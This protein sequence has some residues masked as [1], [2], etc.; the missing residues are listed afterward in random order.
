MGAR[1]EAVSA[2]TARILD[3]AARAFTERPYDDVSLAAIAD[4]SGVTVQT[5]L[6]RWGSKEGLV[7]AAALDAALVGLKRDFERRAAL[8]EHVEIDGSGVEL[9]AVDRDGK[10][11]FGDGERGKRGAIALRSRRALLTQVI[12]D[13]LELAVLDEGVTPV[14][15]QGGDDVQAAPAREVGLP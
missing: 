2:T 3:V 1:A 13:V 15:D 9:H 7:D 12:T 4:A 11:T 8:G 5:L 6:R 10:T 14:L